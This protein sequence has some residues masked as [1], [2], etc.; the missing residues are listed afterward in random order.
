MRVVAQGEGR[1][2]GMGNMVESKSG[3]AR[4]RE[5]ETPSGT[6]CIGDVC[7]T[8][9][10]VEIHLD[11]GDPACAKLAEVLGAN[12]TKGIRTEYVIDPPKERVIGKTTSTWEGEAPRSARKR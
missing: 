2:Q 9:Q 7:W 10:G 6:T 1:S 4:P 11:G 12:V 3:R 8:D 5:T